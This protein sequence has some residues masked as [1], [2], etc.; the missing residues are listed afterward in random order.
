MVWTTSA[1]QLEN[2]WATRPSYPGI[3]L[4]GNSFIDITSYQL[5]WDQFPVMMPIKCVYNVLIHN[6][7][8]M[9]LLWYEPYLLSN[10]KIS[11]WLYRAEQVS[12]YRVNNFI[13]ITLYQLP[14]YKYPI[15]M[16]IKCVYNVLIHN[17][18]IMVL[19]WYEP[20]LL[21]TLKTSDWLLSW[22]AKSPTS[23]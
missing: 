11:D 14:W 9:V 2:I 17:M 21:S 4:E 1:F 22:T 23:K 6:M 18:Y 10:L 16:S 13:H 19:L 15:T 3:V 8:I 7:Y 12:F 5:Q 20:Y